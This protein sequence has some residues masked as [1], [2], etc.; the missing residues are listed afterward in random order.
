MSRAAVWLMALLATLAGCGPPP[1]VAVAVL[2]AQAAH[3]PAALVGHP[4]FVPPA[5]TEGARLD[6]FD[7]RRLLPQA[8][9]GHAEAARR[10]REPLEAYP[11]AA[12]TLVGSL[13]LPGG[14][15]VALLRADGQLHTAG[16][17][18]RIGPDDGRV[19]RVGD[20]DIELVERVQQGDGT[21][22]ERASALPLGG[23]WQP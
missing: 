10:E 14:R 11:L 2:P 3:G 23:A 6:P 4:V 22:R 18:T 7:A 9:D 12:I 13:S 20:A 16:L 15:R 17:G 19:T 5:Y 1:D 8:V 21:W